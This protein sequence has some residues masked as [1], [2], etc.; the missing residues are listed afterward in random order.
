MQIQQAY[1]DAQDGLVRSSNWLYFHGNRFHWNLI[2]TY[3]NPTN[4]ENFHRFTKRLC[5]RIPDLTV[6]TQRLSG[7]FH[8][9]I[10]PHFHSYYHLC[11]ELI[12]QVLT[13]RESHW[14]LPWCC[15]LYTSPSPRD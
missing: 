3:S 9:G 14:L 12:P 10:H 2:D 11:T 6:K 4:G 8:L 7:H 13:Q 5:G 1:L 15:L